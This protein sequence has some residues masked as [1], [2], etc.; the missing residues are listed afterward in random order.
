MPLFLHLFPMK[1]WDTILVFQMLSFKPTLS[2]SSFTFIKRLFSSSSLSV[3]QVVSSAYLRLLIFLLAILIPV[4]ASSSPA[5]LMM[6]S[7]YMLNK[8]GDNIQP[9]RNPFPIWNQSV[10]PHPVL[11]VASWPAYMFQPLVQDKYLSFDSCSLHFLTSHLYFNLLW[12]S[13]FQTNFI[14]ISLL[15]VNNDLNYVKICEDFPIG[16]MT[17][18]SETFNNHHYYHLPLAILP[19]LNLF[20]ITIL[21]FVA[22]ITWYASLRSPLLALLFDFKI[23][24]EPGH[25][26]T[27]S[28]LRL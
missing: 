2:L 4:C 23:C 8:Q 24:K 27:S 28:L 6:C 25:G 15:K 13:F 20:W 12:C 11:T 18:L 9:W 22:S 7:A 17:N 14:K 1:W 10:G 3:I 26:P 21:S 19:Y 16:H 5:F